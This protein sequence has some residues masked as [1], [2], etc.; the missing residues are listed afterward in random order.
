[1]CCYYG[2]DFYF[3]LEHL[4]G[5]IYYCN[6]LLLYFYITFSR[7]ATVDKGFFELTNDVVTKGEC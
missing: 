4:K 3:F 2:Y 7:E 6:W 5:P 1:M